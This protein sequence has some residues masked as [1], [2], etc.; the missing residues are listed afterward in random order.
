MMNKNPTIEYIKA[1]NNDHPSKVWELTFPDRS[2]FSMV[3]RGTWIFNEQIDVNTIKAGLGKLLSYYPHLCGRM[4]NKPGIDLTNDGISFAVADEKDLSIDD[5]D[6]IK[7]PAKRFSIN[8]KPSRIKRGRDPLMSV[9][10]TRLNDGCVLGIQCSHMCMDGYSFYT[11]VYNWGQICRNED[12]VKPILDQSLVQAPEDMSKKEAIDN[13]LEHGWIRVSK[14]SFLKVLP[15]VLTGI[16]RKRIHAFHFPADSLNELKKKISSDNDINCSS[17]TALSAYIVKKCI[18]HFQHDK[19]TQCKQ[20]SVTNIRNRLEG[21][22]SNYVGN[23]STFVPTSSF[24]AGASI[25]EIARNI[26]RALEPIRQT[27][28]KKIKELWVIGVHTIKYKL[29]VFHFDFTEGLKKKPTLFNINNFSKLP[30][31]DVDFGSG[32]PVSAIPHDLGDQILV[33]P[34]RPEKGGVEVYFAAYMKNKK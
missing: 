5:I 25:D 26:H 33:W 13:A 2:C 30:I 31:Y 7:N 15:T 29:M 24:P 9:K 21:L 32:R 11:M 4:R 16:F 18:R 19:E 27:P 28:S 14:F 23:A 34:A 3:L 1:D 17:N 8:I 22:P 6:K 12:F 10:I 20:V